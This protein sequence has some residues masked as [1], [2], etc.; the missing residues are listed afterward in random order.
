ML[1]S[2]PVCLYVAVYNN[3]VGPLARTQYMDQTVQHTSRIRDSFTCYGVAVPVLDLEA[4][5]AA[6]ALMDNWIMI[7]GVPEQ[8]HTDRGT[9]FTSNVYM[10]AM[11]AI[12]LAAIE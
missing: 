3:T 2:C 1:T 12:P 9:S 7:P 6:C 5:A 10:A 8:I 4:E 11:D